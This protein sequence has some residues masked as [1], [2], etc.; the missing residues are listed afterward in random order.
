MPRSVILFSGSWTDLSLEDLAS[1]ASEWGYH[2]FELACWGDHFDVAQASDDDAYCAKRLAL[3]RGLDLIVPVLSN[4][5]VGQAICDV[6]DAR[7][8]PLL[9]AHVWGDGDPAGVARRAVAEMVETVHAAQHVGASVVSGFTG[10]P[11]WSYVGGY[12]AATSEVVEAA[13]AD[14]ATRFEPILDACQECGVRFAC[15]VH[16]GQLAFD[17][18]SAELLLDAVRGREDFGFLLDP[19]HLHWQGV[20]PVEFI[21]RFPQ[22]IF[23]V[24]IKDVVLTLNGRTGLLSGYY[25]YGDPRRGWEPRSPGRG[26]IDWEALIRA[27]NEIGYDGALSV[28]W[29][30]SGMNPSFGAEEACQFVKRLDFEPAPA[31]RNEVFREV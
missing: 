1:K 30:D 29:K 12:P 10:S 5:R 25:S 26:G 6:I 31:R 11:I 4:H 16:P 19:S 24:H 18:Y 23:H 20:D 7:H 3:L 21:R 17:L 9:P 14:F 15:E 13:Y 22:R 8:Q 28:E 2:G 27:L